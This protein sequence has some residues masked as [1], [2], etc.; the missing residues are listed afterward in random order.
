MS[1][2]LSVL[3]VDAS[4]S[5]AET[6]VEHLRQAGY[7]PVSRRVASADA[8][9]AALAETGFDVVLAEYES[10]ELGA[11]AALAI[12]KE[13]E[14]DVPFVI[15]SDQIG[16][17]TAVRAL[18]AGA[19]NCIQRDALARL[20]ITVERELR[21]AQVRRERRQAQRALRESETRFRTLAETASDAILT[22]DEGDRIVFANQAAETIFGHPVSALIGRPVA[23]ILPEYRRTLQ[24]TEPGNPPRPRQ[25]VS[26]TGRRDDGGLVPL[27]VSCGETARDGRRLFTVIAR[28]VTERRRAEDALREQ[29]ERFRLAAQTSSDLVYEWDIA[30][31]KLLL[32]GQIGEKLGYE[33]GE[34][35]HHVSSWEKLAHPEDRHRVREAVIRHIRTSAPYRE[36]YRVVGKYG[37]VHVWMDSGYA[38]RDANGR[39]VRWIGVVTDVTERRMTE[40]ALKQSEQRLRTLVANAPVVLFALDRDGIFTHSEGKGLEALGLKPG[41]AVGRS[42]RD[43]YRDAPDLLEK[44]GRALAGE[45]FSGPIAVGDLVF[46]TQFAPFRGST[47]DVIG[48]VGVST[49]VTEQRRARR[50]AET[51][52][53]RYRTLFERNLAG[54]FRSTLEGPILDCN[55]SFA[56]IFGYASHDDAVAHSAVDFYQTPEDRQAMLRRLKENNALTNYEACL[57]RTDGSLVWILENAT[58]VP[59]PDGQP[60]IIEGTIIDITERKRAEEQVKRLAFHDALTELPNRLLFHD[61]L[62]MAIALAARQPQRLAVLFLDLDRFKVIND[63]L[64]H[65]TGDQIL[66]GA[67]ERLRGCVR[68]GDT[69]AR[70]GGDEFTVLIAGLAA[71]E[72]ALKV[73]HKILET[74]RLPFRIDGR[75]LFVTTSIGIA[76]YPSDGLDAETLVRNAD[77]AMYRAK[78]QGRDHCQLYTP[79]MNSRALERLSLES[80]LRQALQNEELTIHYQP[81]VDIASGVVRGAEALLRWN[82]PELGLLPPSEFIP[83]A[84]ASGLI[85]GVGEWV[86]RRAC[87][88][89][90]QWH[91]RGFP[92]LSVA[93]NLST[94]Q[95]QQADLVSQVTRALADSN[96]PAGALELEITETNAMQNAEASVVAL[97]GLKALGVKI[98]L[99][100]FGTGYSSL[101]YLKRFP[102]DSIKLDQS[103]VHDVTSD[104]D[105]AAIATAVIAMAHSLELVVVAEGVETEDQLAFLRQHACDL[106]Q[107][108]LLASAMPAE[109]FEQFLLA[110][111]TLSTRGQRSSV[112]SMPVRPL[113]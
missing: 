63:S 46:E 50:A 79:A 18:K 44:V 111:S 8:F 58:L 73:A 84:E 93:V 91:D 94:R 5:N 40:W 39:A 19:N 65:S 31:G 100:D 56:R 29:E 52:E 23:V 21:E 11:L 22:V 82:H 37:S 64:G 62:S 67:A 102:I 10:S 20:G 92:G 48:V 66:R 71:D 33:P 43:L 12:L 28:D 15:V 6:L 99:D 89:M 98:S 53:L 70:L 113:P 47:G 95:F 49:D 59:G 96:L 38:L 97:G 109:D 78:D 101:S 88:Q 106:M 13:L 16:E 41:E 61:R 69:V 86:L 27:E 42:V 7:D 90:R 57:R 24:S 2:P 103:F 4:A 9:R 75:E 110:G 81:V 68:E 26:L 36:E 108:H 83:L 105:D 87:E 72:D 76:L 85:L 107:G 51:S 77:T 14:L 74:I 17:E 55:D 35:P 54:V 34:V 80:R 60:G 3:V 112:I 30:T 45:P 32:F 25:A 1:K 104:P